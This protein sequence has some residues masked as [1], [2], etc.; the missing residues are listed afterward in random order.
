MAGPTALYPD[1]G[2]EDYGTT[3]VTLAS[4]CIGGAPQ[5]WCQELPPNRHTPLTRE[6]PFESDYTPRGLVV[7]HFF[8][9]RGREGWRWVGVSYEAEA[10]WF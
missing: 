1:P 3:H 4:T 5:I 9:G 7:A 2:P 6:T 10:W 8:R